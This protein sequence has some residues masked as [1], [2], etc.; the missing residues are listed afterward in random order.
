MMK[1]GNSVMVSPLRLRWYQYRLRTLL[2]LVVLFGLFMNCWAVKRE[3]DRKRAAWIAGKQYTEM[4]IFGP[5]DGKK[6]ES[7][8]GPP[9]EDEVLWILESARPSPDNWPLRYVERSNVRL[10]AE[11][12]SDNVGLPRVMP[13]VGPCQPHFQSYKC[14]ICFTEVTRIAWFIPVFSR[15]RKEEMLVNHDHLHEF[16]NSRDSCSSPSKVASFL[17]NATIANQ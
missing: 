13:L 5:L 14:V 10:A 11:P 15:E 4:P 16:G 6:A 7:E 17:P 9:C 8:V 3:R 2:L 1:E 12:F